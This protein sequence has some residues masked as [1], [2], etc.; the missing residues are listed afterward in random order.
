MDGAQQD[1]R[2]IK[3]YFVIIFVKSLTVAVCSV[4][5]LYFM[6]FFFTLFSVQAPSKI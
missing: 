3:I 5:V 1:K 2:G 4:L 6:P